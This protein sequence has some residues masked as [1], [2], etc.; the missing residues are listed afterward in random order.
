MATTMLPL[1]VPSVVRV[2]W[3]EGAD[4]IGAVAIASL[5]F[6]VIV[7]AVYHTAVRR[8]T[9][10]LTLA[11]ASVMAIVTT[12]VARL[13]MDTLDLGLFGLMLITAFIVLEVTLAVSWLR[14][15]S[16]GEAA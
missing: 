2:M 15:Q 3:P 14:R 1:L 16:R 4:T 8:D 9:F 5:T 13:L 10:M 12:A 11:A 6:L 7:T